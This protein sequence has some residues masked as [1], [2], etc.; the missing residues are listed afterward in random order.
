MNWDACSPS[1][2][3]RDVLDQTLVVVTA[4]HG[5]QFGEHREVR[6]PRTTLRP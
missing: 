2:K 1:L 5:E 3:R 6:C 4:D